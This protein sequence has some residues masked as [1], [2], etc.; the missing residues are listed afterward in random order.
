MLWLYSKVSEGHGRPMLEVL[1]KRWY[2]TTTLYEDLYLKV[3]IAVI[4]L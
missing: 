3:Y 4:V 1:S 2:P